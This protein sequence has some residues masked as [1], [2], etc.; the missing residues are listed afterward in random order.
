MLNWKKD[1]FDYVLNLKKDE[2]EKKEDEKKETLVEIYDFVSVE[3]KSNLIIGLLTIKPKF[4][5]I[6]KISLRNLP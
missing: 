3:F 2:F 1:E 6:F 5:H 4:N